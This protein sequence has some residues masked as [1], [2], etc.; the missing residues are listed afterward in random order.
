MTATEK[1]AKIDA[2][3]AILKA[4]AASGIAGMPPMMGGEGDGN[5]AYARPRVLIWAGGF[6][7]QAGWAEPWLHAVKYH[8]FPPK[9]KRKNAES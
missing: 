2:L 9:F 6:A 3:Q 7:P 5:P 4:R 1:Q 8:P